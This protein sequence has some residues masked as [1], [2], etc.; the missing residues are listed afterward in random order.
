MNKIITIIALVLLVGNYSYAQSS[1]EEGFQRKGR[2]LVETGYNIVGG[3]N[4]STGANVLLDVDGGS[5][6]ALGADMGKMLT[7]N[8]ALKFRLGILSG[9]GLSLTN[10]AGGVK[11]YVGGKVPIELTAGILDLGPRSSNF[12]ANLKLGYA[13]NLADNIT[14]EPS[15]GLV[16]IDEAAISFGMSFAMFL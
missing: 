15:L 5:V 8:L 2:F 4:S 13:A 1:E 14:L 11:Y 3:Y 10:I 12:N 6:T 9:A 16:V 7:N